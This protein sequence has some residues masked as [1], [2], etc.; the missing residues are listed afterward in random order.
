M[1]PSTVHSVPAGRTGSYAYS[2]ELRPWL[3]CNLTDFDGVVVHGAWTYSGWAAA[4]ECRSAGIP[5]AYYPHGMLDYW[6]VY[7][8]GIV[9]AAKKQAYWIFRERQVA[10]HARCTLFTTVREQEGTEKA[11]P[12]AS[13][14]RILRPYGLEVPPPPALEPENPALL[15]RPDSRVAL[16]LGRLHPKKNIELLIQAWRDAG[17]VAPWRLLIAGSG[18]AD[19]EA[20]LKRMVDDLGQSAAI[21]FSGFVSGI[22][23]RYLLGRAEW[24]LLSSR[25]ENF[26]IAV[27]EAI[28][29]GCAVA[30]SEQVYLAESF[31]PD[32]E[33]LPVSVKA[34]TEFF[35]TRM[36]NREWRDHVWRNDRDHLLKQFR[37]DLIVNQWK[38]TFLDLFPKQ[39]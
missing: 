8:Q 28:A 18:E 12:I 4:T 15:Q 14:K 26:G 22:D 37:M 5:Y 38:E 17:M 9:K 29:Q 31:P 24:F 25:Q 11:F 39:R 35:Q 27:L 16:F 21:Q 19:Y 2:G 7:G 1:A 36:R 30:I 33:V 3:R 13:T 10:N 23:K 20:H 32:S 34:W 6:S